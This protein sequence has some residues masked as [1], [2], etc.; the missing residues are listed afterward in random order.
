VDPEKMEGFLRFAREAV[1]GRKQMIVTHSAQ[2]PE[3]YASTTETADYLISQLG[4]VRESVT[5][6]W[7]GGLKLLSRFRKGRLSVYG[8]AGDTAVDHMRHL[9]NLFALLERL[10]E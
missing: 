8:F 2:R 9:R 7:P 6:E 1:A 4:G 3:D 5:E 10:R